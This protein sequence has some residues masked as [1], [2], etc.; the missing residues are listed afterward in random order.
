MIFLFFCVGLWLKIVLVGVYSYLWGLNARVWGCV[1]TAIISRFVSFEKDAGFFGIVL[2]YKFSISFTYLVTYM[3]AAWSCNTV[4]E[5]AW[6]P[7][8]SFQSM[9]LK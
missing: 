3:Y 4:E 5:V 8:T 2:G 7:H 1:P 9:A 6:Y